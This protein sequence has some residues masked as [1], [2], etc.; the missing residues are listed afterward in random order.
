MRV[1]FLMTVP[2]ATAMFTIAQP[3]VP[4]AE[5]PLPPPGFKVLRFDEDYS[6]LAN[7]ANR[8]D[9]S[10]PIKYIPLQPGD[11][12]WH[13]TFGGE[14]RERVEGIYDPR[15]GIGGGGSDSYLLQRITLLADV[16]LG[17]HVRLFAEG[18]S[19]VVAGES[20]PP[21]PVQQDPIDLQFAFIDV[22]PWLADTERLTLRAGRFGMSLGAGRLVAT[23]AAPNIPSRFDG[24]EALYTRSNWNLT[25]FITRPAKDA[26][27]I[28]A[29][30][31]STTFW[32]LY[33]THYFDTPHQHR[34][35]FVLF[36]HPSRARSIC[37]GQRRRTAPLLRGARVRRLEALG[38]GRRAGR[39]IWN[40]WRRCN[41]C[42]DGGDER[43]LHLGGPMAPAGRPESRSR[44]WGRQRRRWPPGNV[45]STLLQI[46]IFQRCQLAASGK[47]Y[48]LSSL[49]WSPIVQNGFGRRGRRLVLEVFAERRCLRRARVFS[50]PALNDAPAYIGTAL[51]VNLTWQ[52]QRHVT[53]QASYVHFLTGTYVHEAGGKD[54]N[55]FSTTIS[56]LF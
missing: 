4:D 23:R 47:H 14:L 6:C 22:V 27:Y 33:T 21:P 5:V 40:D 18:I 2:A 53:F 39:A 30:D 8:T 34:T 17:E 36:R 46:R 55:Y 20:R 35:G 41:P 11:P 12:Q 13:V 52:V 56:F 43:G 26:G 48:W 50:I 25:A 29:E 54:V 9:W 51:D 7:P 3:I 32:G 24:F 1:A 42:V 19:G 49:P 31:H 28:E 37:L 38:L 45:R 16:H 44:Q 10:D 15:F